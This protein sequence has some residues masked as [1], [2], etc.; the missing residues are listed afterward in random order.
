[1]IYTTGKNY[2][3]KNKGYRLGFFIVVF[4]L[5]FSQL[6]AQKFKSAPWENQRQPGIQRV[7]YSLGE[8]FTVLDKKVRYQF[9]PSGS[10]VSGETKSTYY[11][12]QVAEKEGVAAL[13]SFVIH[14]PSGFLSH[15]DYRVWQ[16]GYIIACPQ[17][18]LN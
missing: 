16:G 18:P 15:L 3:K 9:F 14:F 12:I 6:P 1:M 11:R 13:D 7:N 17:A 8:D 5:F 2:F 4:V 10:G